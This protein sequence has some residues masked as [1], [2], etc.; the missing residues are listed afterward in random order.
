MPRAW[1]GCLSGSSAYPCMDRRSQRAQC[2]ATSP[3]LRR[4]RA[5]SG[6]APSRGTSE[7][8]PPPRRPWPQGPRGGEACRAAAAAPQSAGGDPRPPRRRSTAR[9]AK[10]APRGRRQKCRCQRRRPGR[11]AAPR[12]RLASRC[13][14]AWCSRSWVSRS[15][16]SAWAAPPPEPARRGRR[17]GW[18]AASAPARRPRA[19]AA[20]SVA[21]P[22]AP[23]AC[24]S[25]S[26]WP[27]HVAGKWRARTRA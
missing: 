17:P 20:T 8:R 12:A 7:G 21:V 25:G 5:P 24:S 26:P 22:A 27:L 23:Q 15:R 16:A 4:G 9:P 11:Q 19:A 10:A 2:T 13:C 3:G 1:A 14:P 18:A 6:V